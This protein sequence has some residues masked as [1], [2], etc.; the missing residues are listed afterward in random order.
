MQTATD[1]PSANTLSSYTA[2]YNAHSANPQADAER[3][4]LKRSYLTLLPHPHLVELCLAF[5]AYA[6][7]HV[8]SLLWPPDLQAAVAGQ[9]SGQ[10]TPFPVPPTPAAAEK[11]TASSEPP[12][13]TVSQLPAPSPG[14][15]ASSEPPP[16]GSLL[17]D[18]HTTSDP[19][20]TSLESD[21]STTKVLGGSV[22]TVTHHP[23]SASSSNSEE[24]KAQASSAPSAAAQPASA[25]TTAPAPTLASALHGPYPHA[26][27]GYSQQVAYPH[28]PYYPP[29]NFPPHY[30]HPTPSQYPTPTFPPHP[31][32]PPS[33]HPTV[34]PFTSAPLARHPIPMPPPDPNAIS[35]EDLPSY[36]DMIVE[37]L[38]DL[39]EPDGCAPKS[40]F[41]WMASHYPLHTNFRPS[42]S[43][44]LQKAFKRGRLEKSN[45]G[46][47]RLN[48]N[49]DGGTT[50]RRTTRRPQTIS[51]TLST[52]SGQGAPPSSPFTHAPLVH[53]NVQS[54]SSTPKL[55]ASAPA[56]GP[57]PGYPHPYPHSAYPGY[58][59]FGQPPAIGSSALAHPPTGPPGP[60]APS[61][62]VAEAVSGTTD[63][64]VAEGSD[65]WKAAQSILDA[66]NF[67]SVLQ[68]GASTSASAPGPA[69]PPPPPPII[70]GPG[71]ELSTETAQ[72]STSD[73]AV[74][75]ARS[76]LS[77]HDRAA[78]QA[79][80]ALLA[81]QLA[82]IAEDTLDDDLKDVGMESMDLDMEDTRA[83]GAAEEYGDEE[84]E[85]EDDDDDMVPVPIP[86]EALRT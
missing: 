80:L 77:D 85:E 61:S 23:P 14:T 65:A 29:P 69:V 72:T 46:K 66:I 1:A 56:V 39:S 62:S 28:A 41:M 40:V 7:P 22:A 32:Y 86:S 68:T 17:D 67:G 24:K 76:V 16:M 2:F 10:A 47:Y 79:Q 35:P 37:A 43:Q 30:P 3:H 9:R 49:W 75:A 11:N 59:P 8:Q 52:Q 44:A 45:N 53:N 73:G 70:A 19:Q 81:A 36:E 50:S 13:E 33:S 48:I 84:E 82:E 18:S 31:A 63:E 55:V 20:N 5:D 38:A 71:L 6:P 25:S 21:Q 26:P 58:P 27:Y 4:A 83:D 60:V 64:E 34:S 78:L 12:P 57:F 74:P 54:R 51:Q 15:T 42:A